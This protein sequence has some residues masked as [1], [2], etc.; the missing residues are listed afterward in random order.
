[1]DRQIEK[2][3]QPRESKQ[4]MGKVRVEEEFGDKPTN[5]SKQDG[6]SEEVDEKV[7]WDNRAHD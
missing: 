5:L 1:M 7:N 2:D 6:N 3:R 4:E